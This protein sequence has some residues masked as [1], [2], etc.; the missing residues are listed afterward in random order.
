MEEIRKSHNLVKRHLIQKVTCHKKGLHV[1]DVG[2]GRGGDLQKWAFGKVF[3]DACDPDEES[4]KEA[5]QRSYSMRWRVNFFNGDIFSCPYK[6]YDVICYN[7]SLQY[8]FQNGGLFFKS[9]NEIRKRM[10]PG[11][12][13]IGCIPDSEQVLNRTPIKDTL[14]NYMIRKDDSGYG[15]F[16]EKLFVYLTDT[17]YYSGGPIPEPIAYKDMLITHLENKGFTLESWTPFDTQFEISKIYS[18]F[19]FVYNN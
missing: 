2:C 4:L 17:P 5:V 8:I 16:G 6:K 13:L 7:F 3:L 1:L 10:K 11:G 19:I 14:G 15:N 18:Q 12:K 9:L